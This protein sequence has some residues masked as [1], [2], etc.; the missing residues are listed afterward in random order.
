[1]TGS[2]WINAGVVA[3]NESIMNSHQIMTFSDVNSL[4]TTMITP[5]LQHIILG[6]YTKW[7]SSLIAYPMKLSS[8]LAERQLYIGGVKTNS[9]SRGS[10][11]INATFG[12]TLGEYLFSAINNDFTDYEPYTTLQIYLPYYGFVDV[13]ISDVL[14]KYI[15]FR[16]NI[17]FNTG[18]AMYIIGVNDYSVSSPNAPYR[19]GTDDT[20]TRI[21]SKIV[22]QLGVSVPLGQTGMADT[23]RNITMA[24][25]KGATSII[26]SAIGSASGVGISTAS[27][28]TVA[29]ISS[30]STNNRYDMMLPQKNVSRTYETETTY[31][32]KNY[33]KGNRI[34][35]CFDTAADVLSKMYINPSTDKPNNSFVDFCCSTSIKIVRK[36]ARVKQPSSSYG[37]LYGYPLGETKVLGTLT[38]YTE[39]SSVHFEGNGFDTITQSEIAELHDA[40]GSGIIL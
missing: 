36:K 31:N 28:R 11:P 38:G 13:N 1:M 17:D 39:I 23:I 7:C 34:S 29:N 22:F 25:V 16:L 37:H 15:Q 6:D 32:S 3:G 10:I 4:S 33:Q 21:L 35:T 8:G 26:G 27:K 24:S 14:N 5:P 19:I 18:Q 40:F 12:Y 9:T 2:K 20:N 30:S